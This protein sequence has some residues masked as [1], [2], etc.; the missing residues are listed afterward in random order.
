MPQA[1]DPLAALDTTIPTVVGV[2]Q[3]AVVSDTGDMGCPLYFVNPDG[4]AITQMDVE[5][6]YAAQ[7]TWEGNQHT[8]LTLLA[9]DLTAGVLAWNVSC[10][11]AGEN[12]IGPVEWRITL[13]DEAGHQSA[14][15][16]ASFNCVDG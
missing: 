1:V 5:F 15:F 11:L 6:V 4:D 10:S 16:E 8:D 7:G 14:P 13:T 9:G 3:C 2:E 12:F